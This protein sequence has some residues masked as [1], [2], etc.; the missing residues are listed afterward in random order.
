MELI[1][2]P[3]D[4]LTLILVIANKSAWLIVSY[5]GRGPLPVASPQGSLIGPLLFLIYINDLPNC[6]TTAIPRMYADDTSISFA[7][8]SLPEFEL[9]EK[10]C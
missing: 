7:A 10:S 6:L 1:M 8:G 9:M 5:M 4:G 3:I 2:R